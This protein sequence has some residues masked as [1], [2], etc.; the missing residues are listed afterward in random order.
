MLHFLLFFGNGLQ[1]EGTKDGGGNNQED[2]RAEPRS[3]GFACIGVARRELVIN[4]DSPNQADNGS[5][6]VNQFCA[7]IEIRCYHIGSFGNTPDTV[8]LCKGG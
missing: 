7:G 3:G 5:D 6:G 1:K 2:T 4:F 8:A